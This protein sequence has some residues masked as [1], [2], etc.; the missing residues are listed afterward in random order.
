LLQDAHSVPDAQRNIRRLIDHFQ[1]TYGV[2]LV[3]VEGLSGD[4]DARLFNSFPDKQLLQSVLDEYRQTGELAG[5]SEAA[6]FS[7]HSSRF[8]GLENW[9]LFEQGYVH[10]LHAGEK[11]QELLLAIDRIAFRLQKE[12]ERFILS[13]SC[14]W[15]RQST[16]LKPEKSIC[17]IC[18]INW[19]SSYLR[20]RV[21]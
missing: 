5:V 19:R 21:L 16:I 20:N 10:L 15:I 18:C 11:E 4:A 13:P 12:K 14:K 2:Y 3:G 1:Q 8:Y 7:R 9:P 6:I 17:W